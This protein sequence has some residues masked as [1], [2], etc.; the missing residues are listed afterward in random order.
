MDA[1]EQMNGKIPDGC[2]EPLAIKIAEEHGKRKA[3]YYAG[4]QAGYVQSRGGG[5]AIRYL[6]II[7]L[8]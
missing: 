8:F 6:I 2:I 7:F 5:K 4:F 1:M 3:A